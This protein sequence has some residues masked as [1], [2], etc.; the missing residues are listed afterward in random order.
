MKPYRSARPLCRTVTFFL[1]LIAGI[2]PLYSTAVPGITVDGQISEWNLSSDWAAE[3]HR[4]WNA[5]KPYQSDLY[6]R[7]DCST[8][9]LFALVLTRAGYPGLKDANSWIKATDLGNSPQVSSASG[10]DGVP[11]DFA[12]V[13]VGFDGNADHVQGYEASFPL[14]PG[15]HSIK[16]HIEIEDGGQQTSGT[17]TDVAVNYDCS[18]VPPPPPPPPP[19]PLYDYGDAPDSFGTLLASS[20]A[21]HQIVQGFYLGAGVDADSDGHPGTGAA[22]DD[23]AENGDEDGVQF[24]TPLTVCKSAVIK[25]TASAA[26]HL[27]AWMDWNS[28]GD[29]NDAGEQLYSSQSVQ[30]GANLLQFSVPCDAVPFQPVYARFRFSSAGGLTPLGTAPDG[31]VE[32]YLVQLNQHHDPMGYLYC[33]TTGEILIGGSIEV[34][35]PGAIM[36]NEDGSEGYYEFLTDG[37]PGLYTLTIHPP[38]GYPLSTSCL[39]QSGPLDPTGQPDPYVLGSAPDGSGTHLSDFSCTGNPYYFSFTLAPGDP[40]IH[41]NNIP[42]QCPQG[43]EGPPEPPHVGIQIKKYTN[44]QD[45]DTPSGPVLLQDAE[46]VWT[47]DVTGIFAPQSAE[48]ITQVQV[49]DDNG[50]PANLTDDFMPAYVSGDDGDGALEPG[51][52]WH[53]RATGLAQL[54]QYANIGRVTGRFCWIDSLPGV[55]MPEEVCDSLFASD[56]SHYYG[57]LRNQVKPDDFVVALTFKNGAGQAVGDVLAYLQIPGQQEWKVLSSET[58]QLLWGAHPCNALFRGLFPVPGGS[59]H[60]TFVPPAGY[61]FVGESG[62]DL[63][64]PDAQAYYSVIGHEFLLEPIPGFVSTAATSGAAAANALVFV[65]GSPAYRTEPWSKAVDGLTEG[66]EGTATVR[67]DESGAA[68]ALFRFGDEGLYRFRYLKL[69]TDNGAEDDGVADRQAVRFELLVSTTGTEPA[70]FSPV[71]TFR[72]KHPEMT[73]YTLGTEVTARYLMLRVTEPRWGD[74][75]W[76]QVAEFG[77]DHTSHQGAVPAGEAPEAESLAALPALFRLQA[78]YPNPFNPVTTI[79]YEVAEASRISLRVYNLTGEEVALLVDQEQPAGLYQVTWNAATLPSGI[80][81]CRLQASGFAAVQR[82]LLLK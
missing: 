58:L 45:A 31:E 42:L 43:P 81:L 23:Q 54:G 68:W 46:V 30:A 32:D 14:T 59:Y 70:D 77:V 44:G 47:Y 25:V 64:V 4:A 60:F 6:L 65:K 21:R 71:G 62:M 38:A 18:S 20:G 33:E 79:A 52:T 7:Y 41:N 35:G 2:A 28:D 5:D 82:M 8:H 48:Q 19:A 12:W 80:Y 51:E 3:M 74:G 72:V 22:G 49:T 67:P 39:P 56:P 36:I 66:W 40:M 61:R 1:L 75:G 55:D 15:A 16:A 50:T 11:P 9:T 63:E 53:Y 10:D 78:N 27:D 34:A 73:R 29:W 26:G 24:L 69:Q 57:E 37:T 13:G 76:M 17:P